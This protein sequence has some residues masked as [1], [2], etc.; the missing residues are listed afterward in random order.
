MD[1]NEKLKFELEKQKLEFEK[2]KL[3]FERKKFEESSM[4]TQLPLNNLEE[5]SKISVALIIFKIINILATI[6][7]VAS[8]FAPWFS[9]EGSG[10]GQS[11]K[12]EI[13]GLKSGHGYYIIVFAI[14][15]LVL[16]IIRNKFSFIPAFLALTHGLYIIS[17]VGEYKISA[18]GVSGRIGYEEGPII[19]VIASLVIIL[20][21]LFSFIKFNKNNS[22]PKKKLSEKSKRNWLILSFV[23]STVRWYWS[24]KKYARCR[25]RVL[26]I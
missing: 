7:L 16:I 13:D 19:V 12:Q 26:G 15:C 5:K 18:Y 17:G 21:S 25:L 1:E 4:K 20:F 14:A 24:F 10:Y 8:V 2:E 9:S 11:Y 23:I 6:V 22:I 3:E